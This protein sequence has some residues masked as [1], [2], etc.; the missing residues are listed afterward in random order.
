MKFKKIFFIFLF[1]C[2]QLKPILILADTGS[3]QNDKKEI[4]LDVPLIVKTENGNLSLEDTNGKSITIKS[5]LF[6]NIK[7]EVDWKIYLPL[8]VAAVT[9]FF[10]VYLA[11]RNHRYV[12]EQKWYDKKSEILLNLIDQISSLVRGSM[13]DRE[14]YS[15]HKVDIEIGKFKIQMSS[16][17]SKYKEIITLL[18][19][20][21]GKLVEDNPMQD[22]VLFSLNQIVQLI[23]EDVKNG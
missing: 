20:L 9:C 8:I 21:K 23:V 2:F 7:T 16:L 18:D 12:K 5:R 11:W 14:N 15:P 22:D 19:E 10:S 17:C 3:V 6:F 4:T 13:T 1:L